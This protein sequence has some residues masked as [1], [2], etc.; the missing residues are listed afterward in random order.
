MHKYDVLFA[1]EDAGFVKAYDVTD[2]SFYFKKSDILLAYTIPHEGNGDRHLIR[3]EHVDE[4]DK[5]GNASVETFVNNV[6]DLIDLLNTIESRFGDA[7][8]SKEDYED[9]RSRGLDLNDYNDWLAYYRM[10][11][12]AENDVTGDLRYD[13]D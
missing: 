9:A 2:E 5:W 11:D 10:E 13:R 6:P 4:F 3:A 12:H 7:P 1:I 8:Y